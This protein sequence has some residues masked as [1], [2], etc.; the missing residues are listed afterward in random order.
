MLVKLAW[1][2]IFRNKKRSLISI[3]SVTFAVIC[4]IFMRS[5]QFG[6]Y[7]NMIENVVGSYMGYIQIHQKRYWNDKSIDEA[8]QLSDIDKIEGLDDITIV[9][10]RI[11]GFALASYQNAA[12][13]SLVLGLDAT[14]EDEQIKL[15]SKVIKGEYLSPSVQ[16]VMIG[17]SLAVL[18]GIQIGDTLALVGQGYHGSIAAGTFAIQGILDLKTPELNK[19]TIIINFNLAQDFF[20]MADVATTAVVGLANNDWRTMQSELSTV[21]DSNKLEVLNWQ[22][23]MPEMVQL[24]QADRAGG[25]VVLII[26]YLIIAFGLFG[27]VLMLQEE[28]TFEYGVLIAIGMPRN[29]VFYIGLIE[30]F[31][32][33]VLGV[34]VGALLSI[35]IVFYFHYNPIVL[36]GEVQKIAERF[37]F[38]A[39][40]P[41]S[42]DPSIILSHAAIIFGLVLLVNT[43]SYY[44]IHKLQ[45][46]KAMKQ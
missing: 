37:G 30:T 28:R 3:S 7:D 36:G 29:T 35:P 19:R 12:I 25:T 38:E 6:A 46:V 16:G 20:G 10:P 13:P 42:I 1:R 11:E 5:L 8:F 14:A 17:K 23:M 18:L 24:I 9:S 43:Y 45:P 32:M 21:L 31:I 15:S 34:L 27:T 40:L 22:E 39:V 44:K 2:N 26:L 33:S 41:T 4:A